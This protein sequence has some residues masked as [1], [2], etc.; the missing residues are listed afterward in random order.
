MPFSL[1]LANE[2]LWKGSQ[3]IK[4]RPKAF[5]VLEYLL[6][7]PGQ[8]VT[9]QNTDRRRLAGNLRRRR[10]PQSRH[11]RDPRG[12]RRRSQVS[13]L[14]RNGPSSRL[15]LHRPDRCI[16][17]T[18]TSA[19]RQQRRAVSPASSARQQASTRIR[20][21]RH[22]LSRMRRWFEK[23]RGGER[24]IVF[25]TGEAGIGKTTLLDAFSRSVGV[26]R[27]A[28]ISSG[29]CL[30]QYGTSEAY[31][32]VLEAIGRLCRERRAGR[33][34]AARPRADVA[35]ADALAGDARR[36]ASRSA[37]RCSARR[38]SACCARWA[39]RWTR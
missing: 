5:A 9:K 39:R 32:P 20:R 23:M 31:L 4:L 14:H 7:R 17:Q 10:G 19:R 2:C 22:A 12:A 13:P 35:A 15:S 3:A 11:P 18:T 27:S 24:Q 1:D 37:G 36:I 33:R 29:Q 28:R 34:R 26:D 6:G 21:T 25:L 8:L 38:A 30:E 16:G